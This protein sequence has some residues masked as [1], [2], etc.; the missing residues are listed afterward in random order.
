MSNHQ[1]MGS[2]PARAGI[3]LRWPHIDQLLAE[4][5][6]VAWLELLADNHLHTGNLD[7]HRMMALAERYPV[8]LHCV[9]MNLAGNDPLDFVYLERI[10][11]LSQDTGAAWISDHACFCSH[12]NAHSHDLLP[13]PMTEAYAEHLAA[14]ICLVQDYLE[15]RILLENLSTYLR[16][17][18]AGLPEGQFLALVAELADCDLLLDVNNFQVNSIN[19]GDDP[20]EQIGYLPADRI[21]QMHLGGYQKTDWGALDTHGKEVWPDVWELFADTVARTGARPTLIE[22]DNDIPEL[23]RLLEEAARADQIL[24]QREVA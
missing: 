23:P 11:R 2:L 15:Q 1:L 4:Q 14:R 12:G 18:V 9:S 7:Y 3:G 5:P 20:R 10:K 21:R 19:F 17:P 8:A 22:W 6:D 13:L 16:P 24:Q